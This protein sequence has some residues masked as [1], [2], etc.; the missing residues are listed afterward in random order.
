[1]FDF[2]RGGRFPFC[3]CKWCPWA[4]AYFAC[5]CGQSTDVREHLLPS[6]HGSCRSDV[7]V[8]MN[9]CA[10]MRAVYR[11]VLG[12]LCSAVGSPALGTVACCGS[13]WGTCIYA[14][15]LYSWAGT[16]SDL[17]SPWEQLMIW[18][19]PKLLEYFVLRRWFLDLSVVWVLKARLRYDVAFQKTETS[20]PLSWG[21][22]EVRA[23]RWVK[24][25]QSR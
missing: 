22:P 4:W 2:G 8:W 19:D 11:D 23:V 9:S 12:T 10:P 20:K 24:E 6:G 13:I 21:G 17:E 15:E 5:S 18:S 25:L 3:F 1:M 16:F 14:T 7:S